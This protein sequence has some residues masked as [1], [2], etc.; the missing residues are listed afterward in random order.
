M[1]IYWILTVSLYQTTW[2]MY[3]GSLPFLTCMIF[4]G[5]R[6][7][8]FFDLHDYLQDLGS[9]P[10]FNSHDIYRILTVSLYQI[11]RYMYFVGLPFSTCMIFT[12]P[13]H[14]PFFDLHDLF[15]GPFL[16]YL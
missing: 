10:F 9:L 8:P 7:S 6:H 16:N 11:T 4:T 13:Q 1:I 12:G 14:S 15:N 3:F 2:H 5:P